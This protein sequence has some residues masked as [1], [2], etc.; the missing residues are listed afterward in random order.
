MIKHFKNAIPE[1]KA[2]RLLFKAL[3]NKVENSKSKRESV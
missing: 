1:A 3:R 2:L